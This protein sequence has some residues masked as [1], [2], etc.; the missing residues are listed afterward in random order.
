MNLTLHVS[1]NYNVKD[2]LK[3]SHIR[4]AVID[5]DISNKYPSNFVCILPKTINPNAKL[6]NKFQKK[7]G[8]DSEKIIRK[9]LN[10][11]LK[12]NDDQ[13]IKKELLERLNILNPKPKNIIKCKNCGKDFYARKFRYGLQKTCYECKAKRY[14][15]KVE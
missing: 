6:K 2:Y 5:L 8:S 13:D 3:S 1:K 7:Y 11:A 15:N 14:L 9:L 12:T 4:I 10:Q